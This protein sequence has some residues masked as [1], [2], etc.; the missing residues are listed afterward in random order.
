MWATGLLMAA[1]A[2]SCAAD[3]DDS[4]LAQTTPSVTVPVG[5]PDGE[6]VVEPG[7]TFPANG[8][9][10]SVLS[11]DN[12]YLPQVLTVVAGTEVM[13]ENKGRNDHDVVPVDDPEALTWGVL[14]TA[15][16]PKDVYSHVFTQPGTY[17]YYCTIHGT[18]TAGMFGS[19]VVTQP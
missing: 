12:S 8:I 7:V 10:A 19:I 3:P 9:T 6:P 11:L 17:A 5:S 1:I 2:A 14:D 16:M 15:F 13:F 4:M 18:A